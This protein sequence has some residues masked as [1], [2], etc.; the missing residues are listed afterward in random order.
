MKR[1]GRVLFVLVSLLVSPCL[2]SSWS[3][4]LYGSGS[5]SR[6]GGGWITHDSLNRNTT[7][8]IPCLAPDL[9][10][11]EG[12]EC[13]VGVVSILHDA[14]E[15]Y[16]FWKEVTEPI[17]SR[18]RG[19]VVGAVLGIGWKQAVDCD[20]ARVFIRLSCQCGSARLS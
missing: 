2:V 12:L 8:E 14:C 15:G 5:G 17:H 1:M 10:S 4:D 19:P 16:G 20:D 18:R 11:R 3:V 6:V 13:C 9:I 7:Q